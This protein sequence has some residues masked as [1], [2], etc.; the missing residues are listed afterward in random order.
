MLSVFFSEVFFF[1]WF[2]DLFPFFVIDTSKSMWTN[3]PIAILIFTA[4][5]YLSYE[6]E[7]RWKTRP[8][9]RPTYLSHLEKRQLPVNDP[10]L[11]TSP[12]VPRL[13]RKINSPPIEAA[14]SGFIDKILQDFV[15]D[16]WYSSITPDK[17]A[18]ELIRLLLLDV[19]G[20]ISGRVKEI[21]LVDLL[22]RCFS[23][24]FVSHQQFI[25]H[26]FIA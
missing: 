21:N 18:P 7:V 4:F 6:V 23:V 16:L 3:I 12:S 26:Q 15:I 22:T 2:L 11:S 13:K 10:R 25:L 17:D 20:E 1:K 19:L 24:T 9:Y 5:R 8:T 14:I